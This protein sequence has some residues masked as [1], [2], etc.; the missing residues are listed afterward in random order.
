MTLHIFC[1]S[2]K[3]LVDF[4][5]HLHVFFYLKKN[6]HF[7]HDKQHRKCPQDNGKSPKE[8]KI[9]SLLGTMWCELLSFV[10]WAS[11]FLLT[12]SC[13][14]P[15]L[16]FCAFWSRVPRSGRECCPAALLSLPALCWRQAKMQIPSFLTFSYATG[17][18]SLHS[19]LCSPVE[20]PDFPLASGKVWNTDDFFQS[21]TQLSQPPG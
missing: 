7:L 18:A 17:S 8:A 4:K 1:W 2:F 16:G 9:C 3:K 13:R 14:T 12:W 15:D 10:L 6:V 21:E 5:M 11:Y 19:T 20:S